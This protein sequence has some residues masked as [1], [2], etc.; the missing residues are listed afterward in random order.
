V[1]GGGNWKP[2]CH[3]GFT[4]PCEGIN[5]ILTTGEFDT[6]KMIHAAAFAG[7]ALLG[8]P[9]SAATLIQYDFTGAPGNQP[10]TV[11]SNVADGL[12]GRSFTRGAG[13]ASPSGSDSINANGFNAQATDYFSFGLNLNSGFSASVNQILLGTRS[14]GTGPGF[15]NLLASVDNGAFMTIASFAQ[16]GTNDLFQSISFGPLTALSSIE[17]RLT[18]ANQTSANGG[19]IASG[20]T[21]RVENYAPGSTNTPVSINGNVTPLLAAVPEPATWGMMILGFGVVGGAMRRRPKVR[22][23]VAYA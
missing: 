13:L 15:V 20:G 7:A 6:M 9:A 10:F 16:R 23:T 11:A 17:F 19:T 14:S 12:T 8:A 3:R 2:P 22:T 5:A 4:I 21:F 18:A 1:I